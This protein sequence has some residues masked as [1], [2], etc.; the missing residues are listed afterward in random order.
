MQVITAPH[1]KGGVGSFAGI[2]CTITYSASKGE[3]RF[4][5]SVVMLEDWDAKTFAK[6]LVDVFEIVGFHADKIYIMN[7]EKNFIN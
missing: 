3:R 7:I 5:A 6:S 1:I 2:R 4:K